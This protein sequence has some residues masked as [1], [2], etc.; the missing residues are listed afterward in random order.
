[1]SDTDKKKYLIIMLEEKHHPDCP[2][3][4]PFESDKTSSGVVSDAYRQGWDNIF[5]HKLP[6]G[7]A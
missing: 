7:E 6:V 4:K 2:L 1:M 3:Y 5:G